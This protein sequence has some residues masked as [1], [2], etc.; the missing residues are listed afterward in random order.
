M[1]K[2]SFRFA[3]FELVSHLSI[4]CSAVL[5]ES[6]GSQY[7]HVRIQCSNSKCSS[8]VDSSNLFNLFAIV[9]TYFV[10]EMYIWNY[11]NSFLT[12]EFLRLIQTANRKQRA[13][14]RATVHWTHEAIYNLWVAFLLLHNAVI[15]VLF[16]C[17]Y[18][19]STAVCATK[20]QEFL[21]SI[22]HKMWVHWRT[23]YNVNRANGFPVYWT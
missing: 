3:N 17:M 19:Q 8:L 21:V 1:A 2:L 4:G 15:A 6:T 18:Q 22:K 7:K 12:W 20:C 10:V 23:N 13:L 5:N 11:I 14:Y 9:T 16:I